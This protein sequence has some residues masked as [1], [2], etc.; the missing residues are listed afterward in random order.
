MEKNK[1]IELECDYCGVPITEDNHKCPN[2]GANCTEKIKKYKS[3]KEEIQEEERKKQVEYSQQLANDLGKPF[4]I[5][6]V[7]IAVM[8]VFTF[9]S[10]A[11]MSYKGNS[12]GV[13][14]S[15]KNHY[16]SKVEFN[17]WGEGEG[18]KVQLDSYELYSYVSDKFPSHYNTPEG[19]QKIAFHFIYENTKDEKEYLSSS[20]VYLKADGY[21]VDGAG[22]KIGSFERVEQ[23]KENYT[24]ILGTYA[25]PKEKI[26]G[27]VGFLVPKNAKGLVFT[28]NDV[29]ITMDNPSYQES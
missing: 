11:I 16:P 27:Y 21:K 19:Y 13:S 25:D 5:V 28:F 1:K 10:I 23:G 8:M 17:E 3:Q 22:L 4:K 20:V 7:A 26:Q 14:F 29:K 9:V 15:N 2:C 6:F 24:S 18:Y 12:S